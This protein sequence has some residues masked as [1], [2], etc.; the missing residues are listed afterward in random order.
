MISDLGANDSLPQANTSEQK[1][2]TNAIG[3]TICD[4]SL[5]SL[6]LDR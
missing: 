3:L 5:V 1:R 4:S 2:D 6:R